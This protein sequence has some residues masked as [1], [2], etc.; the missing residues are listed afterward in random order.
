MSDTRVT[1]ARRVVG[2][3]LG[4]LLLMAPLVHA[5]TLVIGGPGAQNQPSVAVNPIN[6]LNLLV[7]FQDFSGGDS[8]CATAASTDG[9]HTF[10]LNVLPLQGFQV[11]ANPRVAFDSQGRAYVACQLFNRNTFQNR[12]SIST[13]TDGG[14]T[15][16]APV[17]VN[18]TGAADFNDK[19][20]IVAD[21]NPGSPF[22]GNVYVSWTNLFSGG[23][24]ARFSRSTDGGGSFSSP[25]TIQGFAGDPLGPSAAVLP[26]GNL[27]IAALDVFDQCQPGAPFSSLCAFSGTR[28]TD[29]GVTFLPP[30]PIFPI[31]N[32]PSPVQPFTFRMNSRP[33]V[34]T[35]PVLE[36]CT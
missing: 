7:A 21:T 31:V 26:N 34:H 2:S 1:L 9:G 18:G 15:F 27:F 6:P 8:T 32:N 23:T 30:Q 11:G 19:K 10:V 5:D 16:G 29:G 13:S 20:F 22:R 25:L 4:W 28:S 24:R 17:T 3:L 12:I 35:N 33:R 36:L 14:L